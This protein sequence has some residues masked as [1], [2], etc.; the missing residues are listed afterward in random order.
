MKGAAYC[1]KLNGVRLFSDE[2]SFEL[3]D[4][5]VFS[6]VSEAD[7]SAVSVF[8]SEAS[9]EEPSLAS[10]PS[11]ALFASSGSR[12]KRIAD[13]STLIISPGAIR[14]FALVCYRRLSVL[15]NL[16]E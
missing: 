14:V 15:A 12:K 4:G 6:D 13:G 1:G 2:G 5:L 10:D 9:C 16:I 8:D 11:A 7:T 3:S